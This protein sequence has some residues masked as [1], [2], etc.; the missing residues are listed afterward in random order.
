MLLLA[1][2]LGTT[3]QAAALPVLDECGK[4]R[5][6]CVPSN[7]TTIPQNDCNSTARAEAILVKRQGYLYGPSLLGNASFFPTGSLAD[8]LIENDIALFEQDEGQLN[9]LIA[10]DFQL[11]EG[12]V[13]AVCFPIRSS[14]SPLTCIEWRLEDP[15]GLCYRPLQWPMEEF[16]S[17]RGRPRYSYQLH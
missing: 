2:N 12:A 8:V 4:V 5:Q 15:R 6:P 11:A 1:F 13:I 9:A 14:I 10:S 3:V 17:R 16:Y 7:Q